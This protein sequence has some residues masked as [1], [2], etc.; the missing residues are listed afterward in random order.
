MFSFLFFWAVYD[1]KRFSQLHGEISNSFK[2][3]SAPVRWL[4]KTS[5]DRVR[6]AVSQW[7]PCRIMVTPERLGMFR[8]LCLLAVLDAGC[9][10]DTGMLFPRESSSRE[11]KELNGLW[12]FRADMSPNRNQGFDR[13]WYKSRLAEVS[14]TVASSSSD[15]IKQLILFFCYI[16]L[17]LHHS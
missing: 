11:V 6:K 8:V 14:R 5:R 16:I 12:T 17:R 9:L 1:A 15:W 3:S 2:G 10:L 7:D 13:A 4:Q